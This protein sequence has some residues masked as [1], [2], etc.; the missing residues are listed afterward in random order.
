MGAYRLWTDFPGY[1]V[2]K[3]GKIGLQDHGNKVHFRN[4]KVRLLPTR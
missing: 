3:P 4:I 2:A 1:G